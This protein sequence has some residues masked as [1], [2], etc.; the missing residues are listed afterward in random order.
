MREHFKTYYSN[1]PWASFVILSLCF[2]LSYCSWNNI[3]H[4]TANY[5]NVFTNNEYWR[6]LTT[7]FVHGDIGH[8][9]SNSFML[10]ILTYLITSYFRY[11]LIFYLIIFASIFINIIVLS[12]YGE[13]IILIGAS[14]IVFYLWGFL[15][16]LYFLIQKHISLKRRSLVI[17]ILFL[18][19]LIP[20]EISLDTSYLSH[21]IG[22]FLGI[23]SGYILFKS[24]VVYYFLHYKYTQE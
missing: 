13:D 6:L 11:T 21:Y 23:L 15:L 24:K 4:L 3:Y 22:F 17:R 8:L 19:T 7:T 5:N 14:G 2:V 9:L 18:I 12:F 16:I 20:T 10:F 1:S